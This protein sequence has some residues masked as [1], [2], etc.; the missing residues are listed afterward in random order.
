MVVLS[1]AFAAMTALLALA[2]SS[3]V[4]A[5]PLGSNPQDLQQRKYMPPH[6]AAPARRFKAAQPV[7]SRNKGSAGTGETRFA[8]RANNHRPHKYSHQKRSGFAQVR[9]TA[10]VQ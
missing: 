6:G 10:V 7:W 3:N 4:E 1:P 9:S 5:H 8:A 2:G